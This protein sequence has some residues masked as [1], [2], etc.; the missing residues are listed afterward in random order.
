MSARPAG[1]EMA[2][3]GPR[4]RAMRSRASANP[5]Y[6]RVTIHRLE[7]RASLSTS[8]PK[9]ARKAIPMKVAESLSARKTS[10]N[11]T[12]RWATATP[13]RRNVAVGPHPAQLSEPA[14]STRLAT[15]T[16]PAAMTS[17]VRLAAA[18]AAVTAIPD[19][20]KTR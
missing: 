2:P 4:P 16:A 11:P 20:P 17:Q 8:V 12:T 1:A 6:P 13:T 9:C 7:Y 3:M 5:T 18:A 15:P 19:R 14:P 10:A